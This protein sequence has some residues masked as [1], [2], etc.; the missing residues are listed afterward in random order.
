MGE[1]EA[2]VW[3]SAG[4]VVEVTQNVPPLRQGFE[5]QASVYQPKVVIE[6]M[7]EVNAGWVEKNNVKRR[8]RLL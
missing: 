2:E 4:K 6:A 8:H 7:L 5:G 3:I 1:G